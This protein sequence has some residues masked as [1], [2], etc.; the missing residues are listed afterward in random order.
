MH[1][2]LWEFSS[3]IFYIEQDLGAFGVLRKIQA[4]GSLQVDDLFTVSS[5]T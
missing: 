2:T 1:C 5:W 3:N 4:L